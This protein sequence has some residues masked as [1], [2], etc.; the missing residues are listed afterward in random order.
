MA[1]KT[2]IRLSDVTSDQLAALTERYG[3]QTT[4]VTVAIDRQWRD[5]MD[6]QETKQPT[7]EHRIQDAILNAL[8]DEIFDQLGKHISV[9]YDL[10]LMADDTVEWRHP[11]WPGPED[12]L[13]RIWSELDVEDLLGPYW[14]E[15][16]PVDDEGLPIVTEEQARVWAAGWSVNCVADIVWD[17]LED[18]ARQEEQEAL[19]RDA[20]E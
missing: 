12:G 17:A 10:W 7:R 5:T 6:T 3:N 11:T 8:A 15:G 18:V 16:L 13:T 20:T 4:A 1:R 14:S 2:T 19:L 9:R